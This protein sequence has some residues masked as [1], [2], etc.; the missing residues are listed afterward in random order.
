LRGIG[1]ALPSHL[2]A[3]DKQFG[4]SLNKLPEA[5]QASAPILLN[6][7]RLIGKEL[8]LQWSALDQVLQSMNGD[9]RTNYRQQPWLSAK[10]ALQSGEVLEADAVVLTAP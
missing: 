6:G 9:D 3:H 4:F 5:E 2:L 1:R 7:R 10:L 8:A